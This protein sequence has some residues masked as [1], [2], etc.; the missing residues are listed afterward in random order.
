MSEIAV[1]P[2]GDAGFLLEVGTRADEETSNR[3]L[4]LAESLRGRLA[5]LPDLEVVPAYTSVLVSARPGMLDETRLRSLV[6]G[7]ESSDV[8][9]A[10]PSGDVYVIP[11]V[12][13]AEYGP[14]LDVV[15]ELNGLSADEVV[16]R[17][18]SVAYRIY[19]LGFSPGFPFLGGLP[20]SLST[21][22]LPTP[23]V[24]VPA[25]SVGI[26]GRQTGVYPTAT[27]GGWRIIGRTPLVL[28]DPARTPPVDYRPGDRLRFEPISHEDFVRL[29]ALRLT[30]AM[31][32]STGKSW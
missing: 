26:G 11:V 12:Y 6:Q 8:E 30:P 3:V 18:A 2:A 16:E 25:G 23:R 17:H 21:P 4:L 7:M 29:H 19:C 15:A 27:P 24:R 1:R 31:Y 5:G 10:A 14:D 22:R 9:P 13:G 32:R 20:D 28:F